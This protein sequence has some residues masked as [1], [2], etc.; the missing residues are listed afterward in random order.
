MMPALLEKKARCDRNRILH[1][2][3]VSAS[4]HNDDGRG[5]ISRRFADD[6]RRT[7]E[8]S[9]LNLKRGVFPVVAYTGQ[10]VA[11]EV[12][13]QH[14]GECEPAFFLAPLCFCMTVVLIHGLS[15]IIAEGVET[16]ARR[17]ARGATLFI[18]LPVLIRSCQEG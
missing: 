11:A 16:P 7:Q 9:S 10:I 6:V 1:G 14:F 12:H 3:S 2:L 17:T 5:F 4:G 18:R 15:L 8:T 13:S